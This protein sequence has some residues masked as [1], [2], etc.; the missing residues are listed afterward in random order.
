M[1]LLHS[2]WA[3]A[4]GIHVDHYFFSISFY[5][6]LLLQIAGPGIKSQHIISPDYNQSTLTQFIS[7]DLYYT[8]YTV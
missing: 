3:A 7:C 1:C 5:Y 4:V 6:H 2:C 8:V